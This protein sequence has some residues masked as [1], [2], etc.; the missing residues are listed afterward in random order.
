MA[1]MKIS[2]NQNFLVFKPETS[3]AEIVKGMRNGKNEIEKIKVLAFW[4]LAIGANG[5]IIFKKIIY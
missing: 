4:L 5:K 3:V 1:G 2:E